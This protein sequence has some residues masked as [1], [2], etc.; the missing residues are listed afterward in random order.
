MCIEVNWAS[1]IVKISAKQCLRLQVL[2]QSRYRCFHIQ[3]SQHVR[4]QEQTTDVDAHKETQ[5]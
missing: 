5:E 4:S 1:L 2:P 3:W